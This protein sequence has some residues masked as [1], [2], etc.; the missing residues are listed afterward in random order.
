MLA[1]RSHALQGTNYKSSTNVQKAT[2][3]FLATSMAF[4]G[5]N[6]FFPSLRPRLPVPPF[7]AFLRSPF[8]LQNGW[9]NMKLKFNPST[10]FVIFHQTSSVCENFI[11]V[12][13]VRKNYRFFIVIRRVFCKVNISSS[14]NI[15]KVVLN[16]FLR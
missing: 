7:S 14:Q 10:L 1:S 4:I 8:C 12:C 15:R 6:Y 16:S 9:M 11:C 2:L 3:N 13:A 5:C